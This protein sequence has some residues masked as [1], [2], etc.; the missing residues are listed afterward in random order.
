MK[1]EIVVDPACEEKV[2][3]YTREQNNLTEAIRQLVEDQPFEL[4]GYKNKEIVRLAFS[5]VSCIAVMG[6][7]VY[8]IC[9]NDNYQLKERLYILEGKLPRS[10]IRINQ[11]C[12]ANLEKIKRFDASIAG[13]LKIYFKNGHVDYVSRRQLKKVKERMGI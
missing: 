12:F 13:T 4:L 10:F 5:E 3:V 1:C 11:S 9:E 6:N 8:A 2:V 7:K